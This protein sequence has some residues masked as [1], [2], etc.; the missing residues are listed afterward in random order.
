MNLYNFIGVIAGLAFLVLA[1]GLTADNPLAFI[2]LPGLLIVVGGTVTAILVSFPAKEAIAAFKQARVLT[3]PTDIDFERDIARIVG[4]S[5][6]WFRRQIGQID[7]QLEK[8]DDTFMQKGLQMV[9][10]QQAYE[11][12]MAVLN[13]KIAQYRTKETAVI[14]IFRSMA[15]FAPAFGMVGSLVGLVNMLQGV[16]E[17]AIAAITADMAIALITTFYGLLL[18]N[19]VFKPIATKLEQR[20]NLI[21]IKLSMI[22][23]GIAMLQQNRTP[24]AIQDTLLSFLQGQKLDAVHTKSDSLVS[25]KLNIKAA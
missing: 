17:G 14:N 18:A 21:T 22:A 9:R 13:W 1:I 24:S 15:A 11:D 3:Q 7:Q 6:L 16:D 5:K 8:L 10:D 20:R 25:P 4:F 2:N 12:V 19:L 23:E